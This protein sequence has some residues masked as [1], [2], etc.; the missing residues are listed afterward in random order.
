MRKTIL[1]LLLAASASTAN[2]A[3]IVIVTDPMTFE[4]QT[5]VLNSAG[6]HRVLMCMAPPSTSGCTEMPVKRVRR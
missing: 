4:R 2:A 1:A 6:P 3:T 5:I